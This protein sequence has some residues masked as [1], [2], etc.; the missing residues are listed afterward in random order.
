MHQALGK[1]GK[2]YE[3]NMKERLYVLYNNINTFSFDGRTRSIDE[4]I[5][6]FNNHWSR[7]TATIGGDILRMCLVFKMARHK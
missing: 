4:Y 7:F 5:T 6:E 3:A 2:I 1:H